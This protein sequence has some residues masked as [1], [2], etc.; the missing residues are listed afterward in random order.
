MLAEHGAI[1]S[2][3]NAAAGEN[4][5]MDAALTGKRTDLRCAAAGQRRAR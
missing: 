1:S 4:Q 5:Q 3:S 2:S